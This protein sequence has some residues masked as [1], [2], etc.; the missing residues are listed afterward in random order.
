MIETRP[1]GAVV[2]LPALE[3]ARVHL[4]PLTPQDYDW[5]LR[6]STLPELGFRWRHPPGTLNPD[7]LPALLWQG[8]LAQFLIE[9][10]TTGDRLGLAVAYQANMT[11]RTAY[12]A[13]LLDPGAHRL[14]WPLEGFKLFMRHLFDAFDLRKVYAE[15]LDYNLDQYRGI[16][17]RLAHEEGRLRE[18]VYVG[19]AYH[20]MHLLAFYRSDWRPAGPG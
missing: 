16:I 1:G 20:D 2:P 5:I 19:G 6:L 17:G 18:H 11:H 9:H 4:R 14:G 3:G 7:Q 12:V 10:N 15:A 8:V 13:V